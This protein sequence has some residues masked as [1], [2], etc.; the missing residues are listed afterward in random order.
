MKRGR[1]VVFYVLLN[2]VLILVYICA[3]VSTNVSQNK[4]CMLRVIHMFTYV[5]IHI[6]NARLLTEHVVLQRIYKLLVKFVCIA[7]Y[8]W[9][10]QGLLAEVNN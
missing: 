2:S 1:T 7:I 4:F 10:V 3:I 6:S 8:C 5:Y 9:I